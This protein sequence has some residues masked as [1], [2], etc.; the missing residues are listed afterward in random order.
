MV[1]EK[2]GEIEIPSFFLTSLSPTINPHAHPLG[3]FKTKMATCNNKRSIST[4]LWKKT[5]EQSTKLQKP[6]AVD[7]LI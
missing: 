4:N 1:W 6:W 7:N 3:T 5:C 2:A